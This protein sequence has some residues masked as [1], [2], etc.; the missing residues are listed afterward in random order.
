MTYKAQGLTLEDFP[1]VKR[2]FAQVR[3]RPKVQ[4]GLAVGG[5]IRAVAEPKD[6]E[7]RRHLFRQGEERLA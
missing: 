4:A 6:E 3:A 1:N 2:W 7:A 5:G